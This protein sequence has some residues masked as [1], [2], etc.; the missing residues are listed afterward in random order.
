MNQ[1]FQSRFLFPKNFPGL[2]M[3]GLQDPN[4]IAGHVRARL[5]KEIAGAI[6]AIPH[7]MNLTVVQKIWSI[8]TWPSPMESTKDMLVT[9]YVV[10]NCAHLLHAFL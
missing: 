4:G 10:Y 8:S 1:L 3:H 2:V 7:Y 9:Y 6:L 5:L